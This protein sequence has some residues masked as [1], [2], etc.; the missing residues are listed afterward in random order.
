MTRATATAGPW[1]EAWTCGRR[2]DSG[3][4]SNVEQAEEQAQP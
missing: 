3:Q 4:D 2:L 1:V